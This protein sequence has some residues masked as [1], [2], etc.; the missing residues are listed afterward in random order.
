MSNSYCKYT[1]S[2][3]ILCYSDFTPQQHKQIV[4]RNGSD[5]QYKPQKMRYANYVNSQRGLST[6]AN[7]KYVNPDYPASP[8]NLQTT[9]AAKQLC[10]R[11]VWCKL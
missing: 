9:V 11:N 4:K 6:F 3:L 10:F 1:C 2:N 8:I 5:N 7:K